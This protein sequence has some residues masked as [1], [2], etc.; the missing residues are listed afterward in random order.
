MSWAGK[1]GWLALAVT[2]FGSFAP[3]SRAD[4]VYVAFGDSI[5]AGAWAS[6]HLSSVPITPPP[7][8]TA[9][10]P[11]LRFFERKSTLSWA[12]GGRLLSFAKRLE[13]SN[14]QRGAA[15][16]FHVFNVAKSGV[17]SEDLHRQMD[18]FQDELKKLGVG[19]ENQLIA[20][21][22]IGANDICG[23]TLKWGP[24]ERAKFKLN[25]VSLLHRLDSLS[26]F[27]SRRVLVSSIPR[28]TLLGEPGINNQRV[29]GSLTCQQLRDGLL[30]ICPSLVTWKTQQEREEIDRTW[31]E[32]NSIL[33]SVVSE[34]W[35]SLELA[36]SSAF[37]QKLPRSQDLAQDCFH[38]NFQGHAIIA[39]EMWLSQPWYR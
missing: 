29:F 10:L 27:K 14:F 25:L 4:N 24:V 12:T 11:Q 17:P 28:T 37:S 22:M 7:G 13:Q 35:K 32:M 8:T 39:E 23:A 5:T 2:C 6:T 33:E 38:P 16:R 15:Q 21:L 3:L 9:P 19:K 20:T 30:R 34:R 36:F 1:R 31:V 26:G 18:A